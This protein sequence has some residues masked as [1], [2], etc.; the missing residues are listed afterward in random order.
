MPLWYEDAELFEHRRAA[1]ARGWERWVLGVLLFLGVQSVAYFGL[2]WFRAEHVNNLTLF[3]LLSL[4][5]WYGVFRILVGWY[6]IFH[7]EQPAMA[8]ADDGLRVAIFT[9]STP[10]EPYEMFART[11]H[12]AA[13]IRYPH[14][15]YLLDD[16][17]DPRM[18]ELCE[19]TG[20]VHLELLGVPGAKAGKINAA[21]ALTSEE[22]ILVLD[23]DHI[24]FPQI[25]DQVLGHFRDPEVGFVQ[26]AQAYGNVRDSFVARA[27]AEQTYAFY[28]PIMQ[29]MN[30]T[31]TSV[32][33]GA[34]CTFRRSALESIGGHGIG[35]AE[36]LVTSIRLHAR[37]WRSVYVPEVLSRG[38]VPSDLQS[39]FKQQLKWSRGV[40]EVLFRE[41]P[42]AFRSLTAYQKISYFMIGS[43]YLVGLTS[44][45]FLAVPLMYLLFG[46]QPAVF[47]LSEYVTHALP[48]GV[49]GT[50]VYVFAQRWLC[51]PPRER[52]LHWRGTLLKI[53]CWSVYLKGLVLALFGIAVPYIPTAKERR[54][55]DF[56]SLARLPVAVLVLSA[57]AIAW[58]LYAQLYLIPESEV[59]ITTEVTLGMVAFALINAVLMSGRLYAAWTDR[60]AGEE[61]ERT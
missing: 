59:L 36:D 54:R 26:V 29:G 24:P 5:T 50:A 41:Y 52:G 18:R 14:T 43:Y 60:N 32:A 57:V 22:F 37:G 19:E 16:T 21:L 9:T 34:N 20:T 53:G 23:P 42:R 10:G 51:D 58:T 15:T 17:R 11:L 8:A 13:Q 40:Y 38:L 6:N 3:V 48:V 44:L 33:I 49:F 56:W 61:R 7:V 31:G 30:G 39:Y 28:G 2:W 45:I 46:K 4:A 1:L 55:A 35:L 47:L 12:A 27:A 25:L